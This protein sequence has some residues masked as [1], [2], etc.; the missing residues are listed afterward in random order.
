MEGNDVLDSAC[1]IWNDYNSKSEKQ[2]HVQI[3]SELTKLKGYIEKNKN[4]KVLYIKDF[5]NKFNINYNKNQIFLF[6]KFL[7]DFNIKKYE[8]F[9]DPGIMI[10]DMIIKIFEQGEKFILEHESKKNLMPVINLKS[11]IHDK[12]KINKGI[13][14]YSCY[15]RNKQISQNNGQ[16]N[17]NLSDTNSYL[18]EMEKQKLI[19]KPNKTYSSNY[20]LIMKEIG[21]ELG[22]LETEIISEKQYKYLS[23]KKN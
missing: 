23:K 14:S 1:L 2:R 11:N 4:Q 6:E 3:L 12:E 22:Q 17:L 20:N 19:D 15:N 10:K 16:K 21:K 7:K 5:L 18:K 9:L 13:E 8:K